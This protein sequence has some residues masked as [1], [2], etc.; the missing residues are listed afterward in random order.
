MAKK[1]ILIITLLSL[2]VTLSVIG[3]GCG[4]SEPSQFVTYIDEENGFSIDHPDNWNVETPSNPPELKVSIYEKI[5]GL[6]PVG[7]MVGKYQ[8]SGYDL[9]SFTEF[10]KGF[11]SDS[12]Q[13]YVSI[14]TEQLTV[15]GIPVIKHFYTETVGQTSYKITEVCLIDDGTGWIVRF[16]SPEKSFDSYK[17]IYNTAFDSFR[18]IK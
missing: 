11:L 2:A 15:N 10:R 18:L 8:A 9:E 5:V 16:N 7:I 3:A 17:T 1:I 14:S 13:E 6:N 4:P 12:C